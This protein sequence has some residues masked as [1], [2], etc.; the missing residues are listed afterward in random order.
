MEERS[1][2]SITSYF[3]S[4]EDPRSDHTRRHQ[5][6]DIITIAISGVICGADT[7]VDLELLASPVG[8]GYRLSGRRKSSAKGSCTRK[9]G[10][11]EADGPEPA[12]ARCHLETWGR[13]Q[14]AGDRMGRGLPYQGAI[15]MTCN[16]PDRCEESLIRNPPCFMTTELSSGGNPRWEFDGITFIH[17]PHA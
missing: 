14:T 11:H 8:V 5:L 12:A 16:C 7:W 10:H 9:P 15:P 4:L 17:W 13:G 2:P 6:I 3:C 1:G